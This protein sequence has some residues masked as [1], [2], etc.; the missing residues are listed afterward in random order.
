LGLASPF[1]A[2]SSSS[3][4]TYTST[5]RRAGASP[6]LLSNDIPERAAYASAHCRRSIPSRQRALS[7][8][9]S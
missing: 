6:H 5:N 7:A 1:G 8:K 3:G 4:S 9:H 2:Q